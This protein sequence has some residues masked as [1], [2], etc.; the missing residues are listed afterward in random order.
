LRVTEVPVPLIYLDEE[1]SF[2]GALDAASVRIKYYRDVIDRAVKAL[3][4]REMG[5]APTVVQTAPATDFCLQ[6]C[7]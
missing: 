6:H 2:G 3:G 4:P 5:T 1:R 7:L